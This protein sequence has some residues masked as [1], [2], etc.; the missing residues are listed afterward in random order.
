MRATYL[1]A[2]VLSVL[3]GVALLKVIQDA[4]LL[5]THLR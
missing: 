1:L 5:W 3:C 2:F 4:L